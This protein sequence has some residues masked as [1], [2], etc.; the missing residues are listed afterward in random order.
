MSDDSG[1]LTLDDLADARRYNRWTF[2]RVR[3]ALGRRVLEIGCGTG[4]ITAYLSDRELVVG[5]DVVADYVRST[6][7]RFRTSPNVVIKQQ[8]LTQST[9]GLREYGFD[10]ALAVNVFEHIGDDEA[11]MRAVWQLLPPGG[12]LTLL[13]PSHPWLLAD[14]DRAIGHYRRYTKRELQRKLERSGFRVERIRRSNP[15]GALAWLALIRCLGFRRLG[16]LGIN[17]R[18]VPL[19]RHLDRVEFPLG[20]SLIAV[21]RKSMKGIGTPDED[22]LTKAA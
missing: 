2:D 13:V 9:A 16:G 17:E 4:T 21:G 8:D 18:L 15:I 22:D 20:L 1:A 14:F 10:S 11:A 19:F 3:S 7:E 5:I 6:R 12:T